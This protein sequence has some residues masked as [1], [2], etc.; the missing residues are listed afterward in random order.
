MPYCERC[1]NFTYEGVWNGN[2]LLCEECAELLGVSS[3]EEKQTYYL[4]H[5]KH[6]RV[7]L[8]EE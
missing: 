7:Q 8:L 4:N 5:K 2:E 3:E 1:G 6:R